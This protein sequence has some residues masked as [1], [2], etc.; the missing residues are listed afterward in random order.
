MSCMVSFA[1]MRKSP[2][3]E[4]K[5]SL[6]DEICQDST[7]APFSNR[8]ACCCAEVD[9]D[10]ARERAVMTGA[11]SVTGS[12]NAPLPVDSCAA[13]SDATLG[14]V[15]ELTTGE[16]GGLLAEHLTAGVRDDHAVLGDAV[17]ERREPVDDRLDRGLIGG[18]LERAVPG[19]LDGEPRRHDRA[20]DRNGALGADVEAGGVEHAVERRDAGLR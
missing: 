20:I 13:K 16:A 5:P 14:R 6:P 19:R 15:A 7:T 11:T 1:L 3:L 8:Y 10:A 18:D 2:V 12:V 17:H 4:L 9:L